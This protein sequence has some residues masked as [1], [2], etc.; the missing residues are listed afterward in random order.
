MKNPLTLRIESYLGAIFIMALALFFI[1]FMFSAN[2]S[3]EADLEVLNA[4]GAKIKIISSSEKKLIEEWVNQNQIVIPES[5]S[6]YRYM[7]LK[8]PNRPWH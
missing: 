3:L 8:Y 6:K 2:Q 5:E 7:I 1:I 4:Q